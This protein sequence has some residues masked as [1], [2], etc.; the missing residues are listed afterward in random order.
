MR[1]YRNGSAST[2]IKIIF[3][4]HQGKKRLIKSKELEKF[5][6]DAIEI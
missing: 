6:D 3:V 1:H 2:D 4:V 5:F